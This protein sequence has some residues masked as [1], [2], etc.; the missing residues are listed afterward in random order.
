[1]E[2]ACQIAVELQNE[3]ALVS[4]KIS[5]TLALPVLL[6]NVESM[7]SGIKLIQSLR[8]LTC[9]LVAETPCQARLLIFQGVAGQTCRKTGRCG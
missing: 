5:T 6:D 2:G 3:R 9:E 4:M 1:M 7:L 8:L